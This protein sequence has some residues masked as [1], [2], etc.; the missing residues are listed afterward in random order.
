MDK[1]LKQRVIGAAVLMS[2]VVIFVPMLVSDPPTV[3]DDF[4]DDVIPQQPPHT[5]SQDVLPSP[6]ELVPDEPFVSNTVVVPDSADTTNVVDYPAP[7]EAEKT[8][9]L[10][11]KK[12]EAEQTT[13]SQPAI[14]A[15]K[16]EKKPEKKSEKKPEKKPDA[17]KAEPA[18]VQQKPPAS[19][20]K[21]TRQGLTAW[22]IQVGSFSTQEKADKLKNKIYKGGFPVF[23]EQSW[24]KNRNVF[25]VRIGPELDRKRA[26]AMLAKLKKELKVSGI[27]VRYP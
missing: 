24:V 10:V 12:D 26:E 13:P 22:V 20:E 6:D 9:S 5:L 21:P 15:K 11:T 16:P 7:A 2:L 8:A 18:I 25:R 3:N 27:I 4:S 17:V 23:A 14:V 1:Q 19:S